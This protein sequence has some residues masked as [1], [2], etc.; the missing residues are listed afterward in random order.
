MEIENIEQI[1][2]IVKM[3][4]P[5][6]S[7]LRSK[8]AVNK[9]SFKPCIYFND[10]ECRI[11]VCDMETC[12]KCPKGYIYCMDVKPNYLKQMLHKIIGIALFL[13]ALIAEESI[14]Y[15]IFEKLVRYF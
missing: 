5:S 13:V 9:V 6:Q 8:K 11:P 14:V 2:D 1:K 15:R 3:D 12:E 4:S 7:K 10:V